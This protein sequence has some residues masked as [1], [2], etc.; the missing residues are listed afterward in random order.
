ML[1]E[2]VFPEIAAVEGYRGFQPLRRPADDEV[3]FVTA[4]QFDFR[5]AVERFAGEEYETAHVPG[6]AREVLE[7]FDDRVRQYDVAKQTASSR[8]AR[9]R[10]GSRSEPPAPPRPRSLVHRRT[11]PNSAAES[12]RSPIP[13]VEGA[14]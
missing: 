13:F 1:R 12:R 10:A 2:E 5:T 14:E 6:G 3:E 7:R 9:V 4:V 11:A 8:S